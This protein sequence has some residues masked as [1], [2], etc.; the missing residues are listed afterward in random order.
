M[1]AI[2]MIVKSQKNPLNLKAS[3]GQSLFCMALLDSLGQILGK[4]PNL[5]LALLP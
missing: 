2:A 3:N 1:I 5:R 4:A